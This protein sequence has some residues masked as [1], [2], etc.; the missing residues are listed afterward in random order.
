[1]RLFFLPPPDRRTEEAV[2]LDVPADRASLDDIH[3]DVAKTMV[4]HV[5]Q[6]PS[7]RTF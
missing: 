7:I 3:P 1:V 4:E 5:R 2:E 6:S